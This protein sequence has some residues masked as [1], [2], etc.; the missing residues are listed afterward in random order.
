MNI[1]WLNWFEINIFFR[2]LTTL[3]PEKKMRRMKTTRDRTGQ[4]LYLFIRQQ[5]LKGF[6]CFFFFFFF[7]RVRS[8]FFLTDTQTRH[9]INKKKQKKEIRTVRNWNKKHSFVGRS[10]DFFQ[11][12]LY[13]LTYLRFLP[14]S[15]KR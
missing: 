14:M 6:D 2:R 9:P 12:Y 15:I 13:Y 1:V 4:A 5:Q 11:S 3:C 8:Y 10:S 7:W